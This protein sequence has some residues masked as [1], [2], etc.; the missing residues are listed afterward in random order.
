[1]RS[2]YKRVTIFAEN[3]LVS[4]LCLSALKNKIVEIA[5]KTKS[6]YPL[7]ISSIKISANFSI[8]K[9]YPKTSPFFRTG[10]T[11]TFQGG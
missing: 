1:M 5:I 2:K 8:P 9:P 4:F 11:K 7:F 6:K 3:V 10:W